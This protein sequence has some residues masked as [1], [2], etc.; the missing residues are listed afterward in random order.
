MAVT[1]FLSRVLLLRRVILALERLAT[2]Q[3]QQTRLL[4]RLVDRI[5]PEPPPVTPADLKQTSATFVDRGEAVRMQDYIE[6]VYTDTG[7]EP[8][9][10]EILAY[11]DGEDR[12]L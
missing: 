8:T 1:D 11:L 3:E 5:A 2:A 10:E 9:E 6:R 7:R 4:Q 12:R